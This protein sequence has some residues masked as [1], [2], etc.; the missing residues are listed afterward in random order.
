MI[1]STKIENITWKYN[2]RVTS[3]SF[4][5]IFWRSLFTESGEAFNSVFRWNHLGVISLLVGQ[6]RRHINVQPSV[7]SGFG[8]PKRDWSCDC[9]MTQ[10]KLN[11]HNKAKKQTSKM[12]QS[13]KTTKAKLCHLKKTLTLLFW[14]QQG[15]KETDKYLAL[16]FPLPVLDSCDKL[17]LHAPLVL[18]RD[19]QG[20]FPLRRPRK[21]RDLW[22]SAPWQRP[23]RRFEEDSEFRRHLQLDDV[24]INY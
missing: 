21:W 6:T 20:R 24:R 19:W 8:H 1:K 2:K 22:R 9:G 23:D 10:V 11:D 17:H 14:H 3:R 16:R 4:P 13:K 7:D 12:K 5:F 15:E 18:P